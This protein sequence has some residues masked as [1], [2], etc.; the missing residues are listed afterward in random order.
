MFE[1]KATLINLETGES[2][3]ENDDVKITFENGS[4]LFGFI[5]EVNLS[6]NQVELNI[7]FIKNIIHIHTDEIET[8]TKIK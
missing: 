8:I 2:F 3:I 6:Y 4:V 5:N 1:V 7:P